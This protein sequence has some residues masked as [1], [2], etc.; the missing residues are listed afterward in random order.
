MATKAYSFVYYFLRRTQRMQM[1]TGLL[2]T[3]K[4]SIFVKRDHF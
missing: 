4:S 2:Q 1:P 3:P